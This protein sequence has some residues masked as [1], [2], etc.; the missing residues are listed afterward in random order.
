MFI[1]NYVLVAHPGNR[2]PVSTV[3]GYYDTTTLDALFGYVPLYLFKYMHIYI[4]NIRH[5][6]ISESLLFM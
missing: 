2:T 5:F 1:K 3:G 6:V 4:L